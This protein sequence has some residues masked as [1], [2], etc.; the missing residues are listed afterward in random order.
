MTGYSLAIWCVIFSF[1]IVGC[2]NTDSDSRYRVE[3]IGNAK[4]SIEAI[5]L[6]SQ[7][8][9]VTSYTTGVGGAVGGTASAAVGLGVG[10]AV[11]VG[12]GAVITIFNLYGPVLRAPVIIECEPVRV[13]NWRFEVKN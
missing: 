5:I 7:P 3:T 1:V 6:S 13:N 11:G 4:R 9:F 12:V 8:V 10:V 2:A